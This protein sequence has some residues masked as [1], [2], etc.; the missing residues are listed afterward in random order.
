MLG[1]MSR[2]RRA[3]VVFPLEEH[4]L[5]P[6]MI[7][8]RSSIFA[9]FVNGQ[10]R[11]QLSAKSQGG[12]VFDRGNLVEERVLWG[13]SGCVVTQCDKNETL[14]LVYFTKIEAQFVC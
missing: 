13:N 5:M 2:R 1:N 9:D 8:F 14:F 12:C 10:P 3:R 7:A 4:P 6:I 11:S